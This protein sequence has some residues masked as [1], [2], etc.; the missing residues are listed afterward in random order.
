MDIDGKKFLVIQEDL[1]GTSRGRV[2][3][4]VTN[5]LCEVYLLDLSIQNPTIDDLIRLTAVPAGAEVTGAIQ[6]PDGK[7]LLIN[8]QHPNTDNPF[9]WNHSLTFAIHGFD[10]VKYA[11]LQNRSALVVDPE[12]PVS[13]PAGS[14]TLYPNPTTRTVFL[15]KVTDVA[16]YDNSGR[17]VLVK[18]NTTEVDVFHLNPGIYYVQ[19]AEGET[20]KLQ[21]Q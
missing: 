21:I 2:P 1:N 9:P 11:N 18:R 4:G 12:M 8:S 6:T 10:K 3:A 15:N 14:F 20:L 17:R 7:S 13:N 16:I 5:P 19:N